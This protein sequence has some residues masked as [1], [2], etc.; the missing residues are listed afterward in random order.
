MTFYRIHEKLT[1]E[2]PAGFGASQGKYAAVLTPEEWEL[3][4]ERF[5]MGI[6]LD[7]KWETDT[8]KLEVNYDSLTGSISIPDRENIAGERKEFAFAM[9]EK[10]VVF[11]DR[12]GY[13]SVA[14]DAIRRTK[15]WRAPSLERFLY[16]FL[17]Y[18]IGPDLTMLH[19]YE[20]R[21]ESLE[22]QILKGEMV[23]VIEAVND[24]RG[25][26]IDL[27][28]HYEQLADFTQE[29]E[30]NENCFFE[31]ENLRYFHLISARIDRFSGYV[32]SMR[33][34]C[35]QIRDLYQT[36]I[37]VKQNRIMTVL[38]VISTI[39]FPLTVITGW[40]GMNFRYMPELNWRGSY[41]LLAGICVCGIIAGIVV[42]K[43]KKWL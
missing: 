13:V 18:I 6:E 35:M 30:E 17:E 1:E 27:K 41:P 28:T 22:N 11:V 42:L 24:I 34:F 39:F 31:P 2:I 10:G 19:R 14:L 38:T 5:D 37:D 29:L 25:D 16:D 20:T 36:Q 23:G 32:Q 26:L 7:V 43:K 21:L 15:K 40:Y 33:D 3:H 4:R 8:T 9:D 12:T